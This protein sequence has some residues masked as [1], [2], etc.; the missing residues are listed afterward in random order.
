[1]ATRR[2]LAVDIV[3]WVIALFLVSIFARQGASKFSDTSG[4][5]HAFELWHYPRWFRITIGGAEILAAALLLTRRTAT[6]GALIIIVVM[7][8]GMATHIWW[9]HP[10]QSTSEAMPLVLAMIVGWGRWSSSFV[11]SRLRLSRAS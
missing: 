2:H 5:A 3:L 10:A 11:R 9:G 1:M 4:W 8:G 6:A 7:I